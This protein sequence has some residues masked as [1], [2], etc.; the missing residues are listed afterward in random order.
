MRRLGL[1]LVAAG[2]LF[3]AGNLA[4]LGNG[5]WQS[6]QTTERWQQ[7]VAQTTPRPPP[8]RFLPPAELTQPVDGIDFAIR[9]PR[10][11]YYAAVIEGVEGY[12]F[13]RGSPGHYPG[14]AWPG[15]I[16]NVGIAAH[17]VYWIQFQ[18]LKPGDEV[19]LETRY[20]TYTYRIVG[21]RIVGADSR[22]VQ[23]NDQRLTL[24]TCWPLW[25]GAYAT[26]RLVFSAVQVEPAPLD[27]GSLPARS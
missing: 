6:H 9:V 17:N 8:T 18:D 27:P 14:S 1:G 3:V 21:S 12:S 10:L 15:Q 19:R 16:G 24:T 11:S 20:G 4:W 26:E 25:A 7:G 2:L 5:V 22:L 23:T 13:D